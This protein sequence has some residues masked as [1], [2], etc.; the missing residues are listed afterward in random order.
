MDRLNEF[1]R[2]DS[3]VIVAVWFDLWACARY[4]GRIW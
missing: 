3:V 4:H 2:L 1:R